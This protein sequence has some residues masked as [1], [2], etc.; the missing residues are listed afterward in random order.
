VTPI[1]AV[2]VRQFARTMRP[3][4]VERF[5]DGD[6]DA[7]GWPTISANPELEMHV[8]QSREFLETW[9]STIGKAL[10]A[11]CFLIV[12]KNRDNKPVMYLP[13]MIETKFNIR[14]LRFM[15]A[16]VT[17][18]NAPVLVAGCNF[19]QVEFAEIWNQILLL[20]PPIDVIDLQKISSQISTTL[21]P[22]T[23]LDCTTYD[24]SGH[25]IELGRWQD[26]P[27]RSK[28]I[29]R[30]R[31][32]FHRQYQRLDQLGSA[33]FLLNPPAE[34]LDHVVNSLVDLKRQQY[35]RTNGRD[36]FLMPG[37]YEFYREMTKPSRLGPISHLSAL[38]CGGKVVSAHLGFVGR[39]RFYYV[40]PAFDTQFRSL[41]VGH[42]LLDHLIKHCS[43][44]KF[45][46]FDLGEGDFPYKQKWATHHLPLLSFEQALTAT[47]SLYRQLRRVRRAVGFNSF[48][49]FY[50]KGRLRSSAA[51]NAVRLCR[52]LSQRAWGRASAETAKIGI[53]TV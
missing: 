12:V 29:A 10:D 18:F 2:P 47:G 27:A 13:L 49:E 34:Q 19:T 11:Q 38:T 46:T 31:K 3:F 17:D 53:P 33:K 30:M 36:F 48:S 7:A 16:G 4:T 8:Y 32:K 52:R 40:L 50:S 6:F 23:H 37:I 20:L 45:A 1:D 28:P 21:N 15:D 26:D 25:F 35:L 5:D 44:E 24:S 39:N 43:E 14:I 9:L 22:L 41:A 51:L 42:L